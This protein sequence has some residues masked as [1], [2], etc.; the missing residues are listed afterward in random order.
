[1][2]LWTPRPKMTK[3]DWKKLIPSLKRAADLAE[4]AA[5]ERLNKVAK[6]WHD[7]ER[8]LLCADL[9]S[10]RALACKLLL[11]DRATVRADQLRRQYGLQPLRV[12]SMPGPEEYRKAGLKMM[13]F[14]PSSG[15][16]N[17]I[18]NVWACLRHDL[19]QREQIDLENS[20]H[21]TAAQ[22]RA[23]ASQILQSY[24]KPSKKDGGPSLLT[25]LIRGMPNR[26]AKC[27]RN[28]FGRCGK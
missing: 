22:F 11:S 16:L 20:V 10:L 24:S 25:K 28:K 21:L 12:V 8:F 1:M 26:L 17:P 27:R 18:E 6:V 15:D 13:R 2:R 23:R 14:P 19:A 7:N 5:P 4:G 3:E 9:S